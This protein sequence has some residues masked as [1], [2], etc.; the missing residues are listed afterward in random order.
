MEKFRGSTLIFPRPTKDEWKLIDETDKY[1]K[2]Q[3]KKFRQFFP[4]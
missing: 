1:S 3:R 4:Y 2:K